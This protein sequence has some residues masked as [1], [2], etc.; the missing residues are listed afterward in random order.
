[1]LLLFLQIVQ[2]SSSSCVFKT[3]P[4]LIKVL[5]WLLCVYKK[6]L[7]IVVRS[8]KYMWK[9]NLLKIKDNFQRIMQVK[10]NKYEKDRN[11]WGKDKERKKHSKYWDKLKQKVKFIF[12]KHIYHKSTPFRYR[13]I[14]EVFLTMSQWVWSINLPAAKCR[15]RQIY[16][17][18][19]FLP[20]T[21]EDLIMPMFGSTREG[22]R[23][24]SVNGGQGMLGEVM[25]IVWLK[26]GGEG[27]IFKWFRREVRGDNYT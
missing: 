20:T 23:G 8:H 12:L 1:M 13:E 22:K 14:V 16:A 6:K 19:C 2:R 18:N 24:D 7:K 21:K 26:R 5:K 4:S 11:A 27:K 10:G 25:N 17:G 15:Q 9:I 3:P